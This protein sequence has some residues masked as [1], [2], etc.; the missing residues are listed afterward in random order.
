MV[1]IT[2]LLRR[3]L[4]GVYS[5]RPSKHEAF[6]DEKT[7]WISDRFFTQQRLAGVNP[8]SLRRVTLE[9]ES[10]LYPR[11][12]PVGL[13]WDTLYNTLNP[14]FDWEGAVQKALGSDDTLR[15][16]D[17]LSP[18]A[19]FASKQDFLTKTNDLVPVAIQMD[20]T[21]DSGPKLVERYC[22]IMLIKLE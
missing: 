1:S 18:I 19:L 5:R 6:I 14:K 21:P 15:E 16:W 8:M 9:H 10:F 2:I 12:G 22:A 11:P 20:Y 3:K 17:T 7:E 13:D 4:L